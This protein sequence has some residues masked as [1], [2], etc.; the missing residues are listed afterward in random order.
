VW[1]VL[2]YCSSVFVDPLVF[3]IDYPLFCIKYSTG[4]LPKGKS[5]FRGAPSSGLQPALISVRKCHEAEWLVSPRDR[6]QH[7]CC[8]KHW[9]TF[10]QEHQLDACA[11]NQRLGQAEE[12][13][14]GGN[15][16]HVPRH[17]V[18]IVEPNH[19]GSVFS[20]LD[21]WGSANGRCRRA[22]HFA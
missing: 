22:C 10:G 13:A 18:P 2:G 20:G 21:T 4:L 17:G 11:Q 12:T 6:T 5:W 7:L 15:D 9:P 3:C 16:L 19:R 14:G 1:R 8:A